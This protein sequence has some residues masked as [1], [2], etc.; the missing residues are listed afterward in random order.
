MI[1]HVKMKIM[2]CKVR[3]FYEQKVHILLKI[4]PNLNNMCF[5]EIFNYFQSVIRSNFFI[6]FVINRESKETILQLQF[7][8]CDIY[9]V[10]TS[11]CDP[12][13][14]SKT[15]RF[16]YLLPFGKMF[17]KSLRIL[18][19]NQHDFQR[20]ITRPV[21]IIIQWNFLRLL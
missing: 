18:Y 1:M 4:K 12:I 10:S 13:A 8:I 11:E 14:N 5:Y 7:S 20:L 19:E 15:V 3:R 2:K 16:M 6:P 17:F 21:F 9:C